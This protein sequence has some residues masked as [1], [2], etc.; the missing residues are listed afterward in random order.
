MRFC[1]K[2]FCFC[3]CLFVCFECVLFFNIFCFICFF[4]YFFICLFTFF[5][6]VVCVFVF[7]CFFIFLLNFHVFALFCFVFLHF[8]LYFSFVFLFELKWKNECACERSE[9]A[10]SLCF[11]GRFR[12]G[13]LMLL[14]IFLT[15]FLW[16]E[17]AWKWRMWEYVYVWLHGNRFSITLRFRNQKFAGF[18]TEISL[19]D[20]LFRANWFYNTWHSLR[21]QCKRICLNYA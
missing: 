13:E 4:V 21:R 16:N 17:Y 8:F 2:N 14:F 19:H 11:E 9:Q 6:F 3:V 20:R 7:E 10:D 12:V 5:E 1:F 18:C 15:F